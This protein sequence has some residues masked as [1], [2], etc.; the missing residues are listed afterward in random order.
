MPEIF[1]L[2]L[3]TILSSTDAVQV[4]LQS[5]AHS[6]YITS[7]IVEEQYMKYVLKM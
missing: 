1:T 2:H 7:W 6:A 5:I 3:D 4:L